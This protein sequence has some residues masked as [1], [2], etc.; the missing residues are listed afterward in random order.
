MIYLLCFLSSLQIL[1]YPIVFS[2]SA[3]VFDAM[4][5]NESVLP[6]A[7]FWGMNLYPL[8]VLTFVYLSIRKKSF[9]LGI[10]SFFP[11]SIV[12]LINLI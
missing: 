9:L 5:S 2:I 3:M 11:V 4:H 8:W 12:V 10:I 7:L 1:L 6:K